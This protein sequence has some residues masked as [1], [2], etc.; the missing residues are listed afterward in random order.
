MI[1][2]LFLQDLPQRYILSYFYKLPRALSLCLQ[3]GYWILSQTLIFHHVWEKLS[4][5]WSS[6]SWK[7]RWFEAFLLMIFHTQNLLPSSCHH[8]I[9][10]RKL[11]IP[12]QAAFFRK[13]VSPN[14]R[15]GR[16]ERTMICFMKIQSEY[17]KM[18]WSIRF[19]IFCM[20]C[21]FSKCDGFTVLQIRSII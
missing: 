2:T 5:L 7:M 19:F 12:P 16:R 1:T 14:S 3:N 9:G 6:H 10:R 20:I 11:V 8:A 4:N 17:M 13:S 15:N 18:T 21:N